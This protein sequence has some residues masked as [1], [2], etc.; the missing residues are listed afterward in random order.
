MSRDLKQ[1]TPVRVEFEGRMVA[2]P[3]HGFARV[4]LR[5]TINGKPTTFWAVVPEEVITETE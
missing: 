3:K 1:G 4:S 5:T 2:R